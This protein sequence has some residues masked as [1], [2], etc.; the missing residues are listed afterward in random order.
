MSKDKSGKSLEKAV[1]RIQQMLDPGSVVTHNEYIVDRLGNRRQFDVVIRGQ[2]AGRNYLGVVEAKDWSNK[3]GTPELEAFVMKARNVN[4]NFILMVSKMGFSEPGLRAAKHEGV[5]TLSLLPDDPIDAG[6]SVGIICYA[7][8]YEWGPFNFGLYRKEK[9][10]PRGV[11][12]LRSITLDGKPV[13]AWFAK[14]LSITYM[15]ATG[16]EPTLIEVKFKTPMTLQ[17]EGRDVDDVTR[18]VMIAQRIR[19]T[20]RGFVQVTGDAFY[21]WLAKGILWPIG[22]ALEVQV[23]EAM[24]NNWEPFTGEVPPNKKF[25]GLIVE[26]FIGAIYDKQEVIDLEKYC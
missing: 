6:F 25:G 9:N 24:V 17:I 26:E 3:I 20:K 7:N 19:R 12:D 5:G 21:D 8:R 18:L 2:A 16:P 4:A 23:T 22:G 13:I 14:Q 15:N 1:A 11:S 10:E